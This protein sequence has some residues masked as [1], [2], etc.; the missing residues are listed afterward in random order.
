MFLQEMSK[1]YIFYTE[2]Y[3]DNLCYRPVSLHKIAFLCK[4]NAMTDADTTKN[5]ADNKEDSVDNQK[6]KHKDKQGK[7]GL[8]LV[9]TGDGK[10]KSTAAFGVMLRMLGRK[11]PVALVQFLKHETGNWGEIRALDRLGADIVK[12]GDGFTWLSK[13]MD[14][15]QAKAL[16]GWEIAQEKISSDAY[17]L[18]VL[19]EFTYPLD[20]GWLETNEVINWLQQHKP[21]RLNLII[22]GRRAPQA[23]VD[24]AD[25]AT[26]MT[27]LKHA[28]DVGIRARAGIE[29]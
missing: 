9:N 29:F 4:I 16:R 24:Y 17:D 18:V 13:D 20:F 7:R 6:D 15:T 10:G 25:T 8:V 22:T 23:L 14:E 3:C 1:S 2:L 27:K 5:I 19:D 11:K 21:Q 28:Y 12:T 26:E